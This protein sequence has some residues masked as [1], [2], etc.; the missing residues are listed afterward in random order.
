MNSV[1]RQDPEI[2]EVT[3]TRPKSAAIASRPK[4]APASGTT[5]PAGRRHSSVAQ[6]SSSDRVAVVRRRSSVPDV[7]MD[8]SR[9]QYILGKTK[10]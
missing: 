3:Q 9:A 8:S 6:S 7:K 2:P 10:A 4:T 5:A 1:R